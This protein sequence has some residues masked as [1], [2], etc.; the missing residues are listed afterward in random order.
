LEDEL[1]KCKKAIDSVVIEPKVKFLTNGI[2][3]PKH[4]VSVKFSSENN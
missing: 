1:N 2:T 4:S 3:I